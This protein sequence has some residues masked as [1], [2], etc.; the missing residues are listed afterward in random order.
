MGMSGRLQLIDVVVEQGVQFAQTRRCC[1]A[2]MTF[3]QNIQ[4]LQ[5]NGIQLKT[6]TKSHQ[7]FY[8]SLTKKLGG[9]AKK[10][11]NGRQR[12]IVAVAEMDAHIAQEN[13]LPG[14]RT[15]Y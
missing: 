15:I 3:I 8:R 12:L 9:F 10:A 2:L 5:H 4:T 14:V 11:M 1:V 7:M 6:E 13:L